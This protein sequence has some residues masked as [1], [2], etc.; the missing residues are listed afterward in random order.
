LPKCRN[1]RTRKFPHLRHPAQITIDVL[2]HY[3]YYLP[4]TVESVPDS[5]PNQS[6]KDGECRNRRGNGIGGCHRFPCLGGT[7]TNVWGNLFSNAGGC[8]YSIVLLMAM[9]G[10]A[11]DAPAGI[12]FHRHESSCC[13]CTGSACSGYSACSG[14]SGYSAC[15]GCSGYSAC[16]GCSGYACSGCSGC[17]G[18]ERHGFLGIFHRHKESCGCSGAHSCGCC[19]VSTSCGCCG[20]H[21]SCGCCGVAANYAPVSTGC[22]GCVG[23]PA[24]AA[25]GMGTSAPPVKMPEPPVKPK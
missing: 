2:F 8:M 12:F 24:P 20:S 3:L 13:G 9:S 23:T 6:G 14:C 18:S 19:G 16:S 17:H 15:S 7:W 11:A 22:C 1:N 4:H 21:A 25:P 5:H 10:P